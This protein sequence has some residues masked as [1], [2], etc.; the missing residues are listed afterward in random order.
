M[1]KVRIPFDIKTLP[2]SLQP[3]IQTAAV[4]DSSSSEQAKTLYIEGANQPMFLKIT[5]RDE[6]K[7]EGL[8]SDYLHGKGLAPKVL[9]Y[10]QHGDNDYLLTVALQGDD[11][12]SRGHLE[13]PKRLAAVFGESLRYLHSISAA[14]CPFPNRTAE[15][16]QEYQEGIMNKMGDIKGFPGGREQ[17]LLCLEKLQG[18][19]DHDVLLHGDYC[20]PNLIMRD[21]QLEGFIDLGYGGIGDLH[22]DLYWGIWTLRYNL[23]SDDYQDIFL[24]HYGRND[25]DP[26]RLALWTALTDS[27]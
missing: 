3:Y 20:L 25:F 8:M 16:V 23:G 22:Y 18:T 26:E 24:D 14:D 12:V 4:Y 21:F 9:A 15:L 6:L 17:A 1:K 10:E 2:V 27:I 11:G 7:R 19:A 5:K 13:D